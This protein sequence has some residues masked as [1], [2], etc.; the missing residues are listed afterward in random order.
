M[1]RDPMHE[2]PEAARARRLRSW[3]IA[4]GLILLV[5]LTFAVTIMKMSANA[6]HP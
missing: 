6:L 3:A 2:G 5:G 1:T 4:A